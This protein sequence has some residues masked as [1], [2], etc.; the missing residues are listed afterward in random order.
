[1]YNSC[2]QIYSN[3]RKYVILL[4]VWWRQT[5]SHCVIGGREI[6][7]DI[8]EE[9]IVMVP[10]VL[11]G[12][13]PTFPSCTPWP[14]TPHYNFSN[15]KKNG[16]KF[17]N[18]ELL[19]LLLANYIFLCSSREIAKSWPVHMCNSMQNPFFKENWKCNENI[20]LLPS[21]SCLFFFAW[22][23]QKSLQLF[24]CLEIFITPHEKNAQSRRGSN[25]SASAS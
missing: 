1:M 22:L 12:P 19:L 2:P 24:K 4:G 16:Q 15:F 17:M 9:V 3:S 18:F 6:C 13:P 21:F 10:K 25:N 23:L 8:I 5:K 20:I 11:V 7:R 14:C